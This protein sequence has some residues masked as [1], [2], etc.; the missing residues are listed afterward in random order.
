MTSGGERF[1]DGLTRDRG[2]KGGD[3]ARVS[4]KKMNEFDLHVSRRAYLNKNNNNI[5]IFF[6]F[7]FPFFSFFSK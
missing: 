3:R 4:R 1:G 5:I 7:P 2:S 6:I